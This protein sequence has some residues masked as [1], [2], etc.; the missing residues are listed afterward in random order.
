MLKGT[1]PAALPAGAVVP[2]P[3][4]PGVFWMFGHRDVLV[5]A[6]DAGAEAVAGYQALSEMGCSVKQQNPAQVCSWGTGGTFKGLMLSASRASSEQRLQEGTPE[7]VFAGRAVFGGLS[8]S[9]FHYSALQHI[10]GSSREEHL[11]T[12]TSRGHQ[13]W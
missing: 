7:H 1:V 10:S 3:S 6:E 8:L 5:R 12:R 11:L 2:N 9:I 13:N 4:L